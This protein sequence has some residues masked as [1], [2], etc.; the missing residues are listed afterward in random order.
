MGQGKRTGEIENTH[1][2]SVE[3]SER[4]RHWGDL[5]IDEMLKTN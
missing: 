1:N 5:G 2:I 3:N 4:K